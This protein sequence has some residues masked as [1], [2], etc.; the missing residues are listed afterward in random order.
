M[1]LLDLFGQGKAQEPPKHEYVKSTVPEEERKYYQP[2]SYYTLLIAEGTDLERRVIPF[3][4][5]KT[6]A[7]PTASGLYPAEILLLEYCSKGLYPNPKSG[8]PGFWWFE[9]GI[10]DVG[11]ALRSLEA[12]GYI[13]YTSIKNSINEFT[14]TQLK[15]LLS[16]Q[17]Q[18]ISGKKQELIER[19]A[20]T[21]PEFIFLSAGV[22]RKY[23]LT[24]LGQ[25]ELRENAYVPYMHKLDSKTTDDDKWGMLFNVWTVNKALG[26]GDKSNWL[27]VVK[28]QEREKEYETTSRNAAFRQDLQRV[29]PEGYKTLKNQDQQ[30]KT[31]QEARAEYDKT[32]DL[33]SYIAFWEKL[34]TNGGLIFNGVQWHFELADLYIKAKRYDDALDFVT[35]IRNRK[36]EYADKSDV[37]TAKITAAKNRQASRKK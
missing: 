22:Q 32:K 17:G 1:K 24:K 19:A 23:T 16:A 34:W 21:V 20:Q 25:Q 28:R 15:Q 3:D 35:M 13:A 29:Y 2:D 27:E 10:R 18:P 6:T 37:Y 4:E 31:V 11:A 36:P 7:I 26:V 14:I 33:D 8:Y 5:R 9:Y 12:R 30:I